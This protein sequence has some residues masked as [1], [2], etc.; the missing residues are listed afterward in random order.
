MPKDFSTTQWRGIA[1]KEVPWFPSVDLDKCI[2]CE[3]CYVTCGR[4]VYGLADE[5][6]GTAG[7]PRFIRLR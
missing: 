7:V 4:E 5:L 6:L 3:L 1:R 2:G